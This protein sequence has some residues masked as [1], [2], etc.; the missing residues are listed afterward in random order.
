MSTSLGLVGLP[1]A[2]KTTVFNAITAA[3]APALNY[4]FCT[5]QRNVAVVPVPE[6]RLDLLASCLA[7]DEV[8]PAT[9]E[10]IDI[11]GLVKG[12]HAGEGLGNRFLDDIRTVDAVLHVVRCFRQPTV[13]R[14][15]GSADPV[16]DLQLVD[17]EL[18]LADLEVVQRRL[19]QH[20]KKAK[21]MGGVS[22]TVVD[23]FSRIASCLT[24]GRRISVDE[25]SDEQLSYL[26]QEPLLTTKPCIVVANCDEDAVDV[27]AHELQALV[28]EALPR[29]VIPFPG[30]VE[31]DLS[32]IDE[33]EREEFYHEL[34]L[35]HSRVPELLRAGFELLGL[36][37]FFTVARNKLHA[38]RIRRGRTALDAAALIHSDIAAGFVR[39][40]VFTAHDLVSH[41]SIGALRSAGKLR[42]EGREYEVRDG[43]VL[44]VHFQ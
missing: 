34:G 1:N 39:A 7:P 21:A 5:I 37:T 44:Y 16:A 42:S 33:A 10:V 35:E 28:R 15:G 9:I 4:P 31:A 27:A 40:D 26:E 17:T 6:P 22:S 41:G 14:A 3:G 25:L 38:W 13:V 30:A 11:A 19:D 18:M 20:T 32:S 29:Q 43:D 8:K 23:L 2:G 36:I 24:A 12:A